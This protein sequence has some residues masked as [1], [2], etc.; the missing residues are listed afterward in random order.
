MIFDKTGYFGA[1]YQQFCGTLYA[2]N[3][4]ETGWNF[5]GDF[6]KI[7]GYHGKLISPKN[8]DYQE[9]DFDTKLKFLSGK[10]RQTY[11]N[12]AIFEG[13][14]ADL[15]TGSGVF[16]REKYFR[17]EGDFE[18]DSELYPTLKKGT[19]LVHF[20]DFAHTFCRGEYD[21]SGFP[22]F[23]G[24]KYLCN[25]KND[26][27]PDGVPAVGDTITD[28]Y[29]QF[30]EFTTSKTATEYCYCEADLA[31]I[32]ESTRKQIFERYGLTKTPEILPEIIYLDSQEPS[33]NETAASDNNSQISKK[34]NEGPAEQNNTISAESENAEQPQNSSKKYRAAVELAGE[35][36]DT[37]N[38]RTQD[39][40]IANA[41]VLMAKVT[42]PNKPQE[43]NK[44]N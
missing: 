2:Q 12:L 34:A 9:G 39:Y 19:V 26:L 3:A 41:Q 33:T 38:T 13:E 35:L 17:H 18:F 44:D 24:K 15:E 7:K 43:Q 10:F 11:P 16:E 1:G 36:I 30:I 5:N 8:A 31:E 20:D 42:N 27:R 25:F 21:D 37:D 23:D 14:T 40:D 4:L 6:D 28:A 32:A 29:T 22:L